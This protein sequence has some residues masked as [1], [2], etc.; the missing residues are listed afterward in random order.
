MNKT[1]IL[2]VDDHPMVREWLTA[3]I[4]REPDLVVC[5]E[6]TNAAETMRQLAD[7]HPDLIILDLVVPGAQGVEL[8]KD[9]K[10]QSEKALVLVLSTH[11]EAMYAERTIR[12]GARGYITKQEAGEKIKDAIRRVLAGDI[13]VSERVDAQMLQRAAG[14]RVASP[15]TPLDELSDREF[16]VFRLIGRGYGPSEIAEELSLSLKTVEG[17]TARIKD[18]L[19]IA[20]AVELRRYA[21]EYCKTL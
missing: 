1:R 11:D 8:I 7:L 16:D 4:K 3:L 17:Y 20:E 9:I 6:A 5:G 13:Y 19:N 15:T 18:K 21:I 12:A 2:V 10:A 14:R